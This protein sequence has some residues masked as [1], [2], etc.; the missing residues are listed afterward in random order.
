[1]RHGVLQ[2][3]DVFHLRLGVYSSPHHSQILGPDDFG[4]SMP[5]DAAKLVAETLGD[6]TLVFFIR[7]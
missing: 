4:K 3:R 6:D 7:N 5:I 1:M 2:N